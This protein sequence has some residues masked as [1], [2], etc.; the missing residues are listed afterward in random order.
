MT[1][2]LNKMKQ[3][4]SFKR[5]VSLRQDELGILGPDQMQT[6]DFKKKTDR[7][8]PRVISKSTKI[9]FSNGISGNTTVHA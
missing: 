1:F 3:D 7:G 6:G 4:L 8:G 2:H 9:S 5:F